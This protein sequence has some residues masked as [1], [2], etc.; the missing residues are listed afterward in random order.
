MSD[1]REGPRTHCAEA[2]RIKHRILYWCEETSRQ[3]FETGIQ[4]VTRRLGRAL[5]AGGIDIVPVGWNRQANCIDVLEPHG[6]AS[7]T[8]DE[9]LGD[10]TAPWLFIPEIPLNLLAT[11][12]DPIQIGR[13][14]GLRTAALVHDLIPLRLSA[15]YDA[16]TLLYFRRYYAMFAD[17][18]IVFATTHYV[19]GQLHAH[20]G[21]TA[22]RIPKTRVIPLPAQFADWPRAPAKTSARARRDPLE[23]LTVSAWEPRKN[24][25]RLLRAVT[26]AAAQSRTPINVTMVGKRGSFPAYDAE[27]VATLATMPNVAYLGLV[28]DAALADLHQR[29]HATVYPSWEEGFG[30]PIVESLW[31]AT[32]CVCHDGS[33]MAEIAPG[34]G[35]RGVDMTDENA[36]ARLLVEMVREPDLLARLS[37]EAA[38]RPLASWHDYARAVAASLSPDLVEC[39][40]SPERRDPVGSALATGTSGC[41][42]VAGG[43]AARGDCPG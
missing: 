39:D 12:L 22:V 7:R 8:I 42:A 38:T 23:L 30:M 20:L 34:G 18:D 15:D 43:A 28:D 40:G 35:T 14:Y 36:I 11:G 21:Q 25:P 19:A 6:A 4:R 2:C 3:P 37:G 9:F 17:A 29:C 5:A 32:P 26:Q 41:G 27:V 33:S 16:A 13:A 1:R 31:L 24:H 10:A